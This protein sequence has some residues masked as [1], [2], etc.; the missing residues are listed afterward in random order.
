MVYDMSYA[1]SFEDSRLRMAAAAI[2]SRGTSGSNMVKTYCLVETG[3][4]ASIGSK[5]LSMSI[6]EIHVVRR[7]PISATAGGGLVH[8]RS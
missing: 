4:F 7:S 6:E 2:L 5:A 3:E 1:K 8:H